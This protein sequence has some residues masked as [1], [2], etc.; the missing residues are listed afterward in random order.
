LGVLTLSNYSKG[1]FS[2]NPQISALL[3]RIYKI[4][5]AM[6]P[7]C[8]LVNGHCYVENYYGALMG[9]STQK[10]DCI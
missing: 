7:I 8:K 2:H 5:L 10:I 4:S 3:V 1:S 9:N 6:L